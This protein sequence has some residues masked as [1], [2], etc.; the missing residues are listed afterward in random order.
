MKGKARYTKEYILTKV[1]TFDSVEDWWR[2]YN[3]VYSTK[4][5][6]ANT[7]YLLFKAHVQPIWEDDWNVEGGKWVT[8]IP[9]EE[10]LEEE[11]E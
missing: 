10:D 11:L 6:I 4:D 8:T 7:D 5:I 1:C 9:V 3:N 2:V